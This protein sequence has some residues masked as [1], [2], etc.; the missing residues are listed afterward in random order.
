MCLPSLYPFITD[1]AKGARHTG[2]HS[3]AFLA[4]GG[5]VGWPVTRPVYYFVDALSP[6]LFLSPEESSAPSPSSLSHRRFNCESVS[7]QKLARITREKLLT[8]CGTWLPNDDGQLCLR[9]REEKDLIKPGNLPLSLPPFYAKFQSARRT[10]TNYNS[11]NTFH[12]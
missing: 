3:L 12:G 7:G 1:R 2:W 10:C 6:S 8:N 4:A 9:F 11:A 5:G